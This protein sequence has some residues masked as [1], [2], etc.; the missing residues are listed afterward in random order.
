MNARSVHALAPERGEEGGVNVDD[1]TGVFMDHLARDPL[2][3][4]GEHDQVN[5]KLL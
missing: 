2:Q 1:P 5:P 4:A 3:V